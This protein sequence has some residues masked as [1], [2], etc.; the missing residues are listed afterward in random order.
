MSEE[1]N[2]KLNSTSMLI[3]AI[4]SAMLMMIQ[5]YVKSYSI[6]KFELFWV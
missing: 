4:T 3:E 2:W 6:V 5:Y 1:E